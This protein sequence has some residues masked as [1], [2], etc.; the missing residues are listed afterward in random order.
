MN[1]PLRTLAKQAAYPVVE[2]MWAGTLWA[3]RPAMARGQTVRRWQPGGGP[4][5]VVAP[6][7]DD[8][9]LGAGGVIARHLQAG[10]EVTIVALTDGRA[11]RAY[12]GN[13]TGDE[14]AAQR[15]TE[16]EAALRVL[17]DGPKC[18]PGKLTLAWLGLPEGGWA[19]EEARRRLIPL[20]TPAQTLYAP[21]CVDFHPEHL[22]TAR[23]VAGLVQPEQVVRIVELG[24]PLTPLLANLVADI[25]SVAARR[26]QALGC[27]VTQ[28]GAL[29]PLRRSEHYRAT[30]FGSPQVEVFWELP[31]AAY[32]RVI[33]AGA[34]AW[35][36]SPFRSIRPRPFGDGMAFGAWKA[37]THLREIAAAAGDSSTD[38]LLG[39]AL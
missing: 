5:V 15:R 38:L 16:L 2:Q 8:E 37:R 17:E 1:T 34:W 35:Q 25:S 27:F 32:A 26:R 11:S 21:S 22:A 23:L 10:D 14:M 29:A 33:Q 3:A 39:E 20:L 18:S 6:H 36:E 9:T 31:A 4:V 30:L 13:L 24:V 12:Q 19:F 7:P 28:T